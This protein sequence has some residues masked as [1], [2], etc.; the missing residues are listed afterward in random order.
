MPSRAFKG[1]AQRTR[2]LAGSLRSLGTTSGV[3]TLGKMLVTAWES[4]MWDFGDVGGAYD[5]HLWVEEIAA[6][7]QAGI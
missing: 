7:P 2:W 4:R 6:L 3:S 5:L 1:P